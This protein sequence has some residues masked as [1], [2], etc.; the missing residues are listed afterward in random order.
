MAMTEVAPFTTQQIN[1]LFY[2]GE[3]ALLTIQEAVDF[4]VAQG[5]SYRVIIP[6]GYQGS[7]TIAA[8]TGG[9]AS[10]ILEDQRVTNPLFYLWS[11][12]AYVGGVLS[13]NGIMPADATIETA[14]HS[15]TIEHVPSPATPASGLN[16]D[17]HLFIYCNSGQDTSGVTGQTG[18]YGAFGY[19]AGG[20]GGAA[21]AGSTNGA[22]GDLNIRGGWAGT[23]AGTPG[24]PGNVHI[25]DPFNS[26]GPAGVTFIGGGGTDDATIIEPGGALSSPSADFAACQVANSP[27]RT[28]ANTPDSEL[29]VYP[30]VGVAVSTGTAWGASINPATLALTNKANTFTGDQTVTG[31]LSVSATV[32]AEDAALTT[33]EVNGSPVRTFANTTIPD[34]ANIAYTDEANVFS[35]AQEINALLTVS[36][37]TTD[38]IVSES[39]Q[40][41]DLTVNGSEV[42]TFANTP[43]QGGATYPP[44]GIGVSTG[45]AWGTSID[46]T[47]LALKASL[48]AVATTGN[49][50]D[51]A[52]T[53]TIPAAQVNSDWNAA[54]GVAQILNKPA[55]PPAQVYPAAGIAVSTGSAWGAPINP[56][57]VPLLDAGKNLPIPAGNVVIGGTNLPVTATAPPARTGGLVLAWNASTQFGNQEETDFINICDPAAVNGGFSWWNVQSGTVIDNTV[58]AIMSLDKTGKLTVQTASVASDMTVAGIFS[59]TGYNPGSITTKQGLN[60]AW[61]LSGGSAETDFVN[62]G[63]SGFRWYNSAVGGVI[64]SASAPVATLDQAGD[65]AIV[66]NLSAATKSFKIVHPQDSSKYLI[67][68]CL[69]GPENGVYYRGE[70]QTGEDGLATITLPDYFEALTAKTGRSVLLTELIEDDDTEMGKVGASRVKDGKFTVRSEYASQR[71]YWEVKAVRAD[72]DPLTVTADIGV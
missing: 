47:T 33:C 4:A 59:A 43:D 56:A 32:T 63:A 35:A 51:L 53:P 17:G 15:L 39:G 40:F 7:D 62:G 34:P 13:L 23:G 30:P 19:L 14:G 10:V 41:D 42:R 57:S 8:V 61:N 21:P 48:A 45:T 11:N 28:F 36:S 64:N 2:V 69:E 44:A 3:G 50:N 16:A 65:F 54:T 31:N 26:P 20:P 22:G 6:A 55:I 37:I 27:V 5:G 66:G 12:T 70:G 18:G 46:P 49:Y 58:A 67:H 71:F 1:S 38:S 29:E 72:V 24:S 68:A 52:G 25:Q 60:V 9:S